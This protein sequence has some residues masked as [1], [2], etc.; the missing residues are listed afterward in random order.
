[1]IFGY[2]ERSTYHTTMVNKV[3]AYLKRN[4]SISEKE[5]GLVSGRITDACGYDEKT[6]TYF[7]CEVKV[8]FSD[9]QKAPYQIHE[10]AFK[11]KPKK[12]GAKKIPIIA[13]PKALYL[14]LINNDKWESLSD[15]CAKLGVAFWVIEQSTVRQIQGPKPTS[16]KKPKAVRAKT[17][18][19]NKKKSTRNHKTVTKS[20]ALKK[21]KTSSKSKSGAKS[22][23]AKSATPN[24]KRKSTTKRPSSKRKTTT[25]RK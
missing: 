14:G 15:A 9:L 7:I 5:L 6:N 8:D 23:L 19:T 16:P 13:I 10:T 4:C 20:R 11:Y 2:A 3:N 21:P 24:K 22:K 17:S 1:M 25:K 12:I 18:T